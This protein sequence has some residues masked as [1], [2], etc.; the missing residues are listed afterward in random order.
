MI[1]NWR[2]KIQKAGEDLLEQFRIYASSDET[3]IKTE[4]YHMIKSQFWKHWE[5]V[6][7]KIVAIEVDIAEKLGKKDLVI[8][9]KKN[10]V[11][12]FDEIRKATVDWYMHKNIQLNIVDYSWVYILFLFVCCAAC[13]LY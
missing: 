4:K 13:I 9:L 8:L 2:P 1:D 6:C 7:F 11:E 3:L 10:E 12:I 5:L